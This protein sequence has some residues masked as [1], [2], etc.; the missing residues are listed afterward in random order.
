MQ[1]YQAITVDCVWD[2]LE[3]DPE[4][5]ADLRARAALMHTLRAVFE[6]AQWQ[7]KTAAAEHSGISR[8]RIN[9]VMR[10]DINRL[11][12]ATLQR[13]VAVAIPNFNGGA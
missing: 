1:N 12:L 10:G 11:P 13:M 2:A 8:A 4:T 6:S 3:S 9:A 7:Q 5:A